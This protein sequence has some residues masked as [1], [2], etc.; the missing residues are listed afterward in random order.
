M[1]QSND[2]LTDP[3]LT[4]KTQDLRTCS[5]TDCTG[6]IPALPQDEF[7]LES[8]EAMYPFLT[9]PQKDQRPVMTQETAPAASSHI[10]QTE[11]Q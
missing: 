4:E 3:Y 5:S 9:P 8:Y 7:E 2:A 11:P 10:K 6:L 1:K